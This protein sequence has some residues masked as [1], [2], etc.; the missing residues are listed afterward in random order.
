MRRTRS[1]A[2]GRCPPELVATQS[3][4]AQ[5]SSPSPRMWMARNES[6]AAASVSASTKCV[7]HR[8]AQRIAPGRAIEREPQNRAVP[9]AWSP[10]RQRSRPLDSPPGSLPEPY[11][12]THTVGYTI[13]ILYK[14]ERKARNGGQVDSPLGSVSSRS[15]RPSP[16]RARSGVSQ[17]SLLSL[18]H[19][20]PAV[21][22]MIAQF[23]EWEN[24]LAGAVARGCHTADR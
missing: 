10:R 6:S 15:P 22:A 21:D 20:H 8:M 12:D 1:P 19:P 24:E 14:I 23:A 7:D 16:P 4:P 11:T 5:K 13:A 9:A 2:R 18:E 3:A 17:A